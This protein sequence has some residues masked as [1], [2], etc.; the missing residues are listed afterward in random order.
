LSVAL[1]ALAIG[2]GALQ[3]AAKLTITGTVT[4]TCNTHI[5]GQASASITV[6]PVTALSGTSTLA[7]TVPSVPAGL[8]VSPSTSQTLNATTAKT[9]TY[10]V[11]PAAGCSGFTTGTPTLTFFAAGAT[12]AS[13]TVHDTLSSAPALSVS[14]SPATLTCN[15]QSGVA[16]PPTLTVTPAATLGANQTIPVAIPTPP[17]G[18]TIT[19]VSGTTLSSSVTSLSYTVNTASSCAN[20]TNGGT[21]SFNFTANGITDAS[22]TVNEVVTSNT[23]LLLSQYS[24]APTCDTTKGPV[25]QPIVVTPAIP[26]TSGTIAVTFTPPS[27]GLT[28]TAPNVTTLSPTVT[29]LT[30]TVSEAAGCVGV[31]NNG[32]PSVVFNAGGTPDAT[33]TTTTTLANSTSGLAVNNAIIN[34]NCTLVGTTYTPGAAQVVALT[35]TATGGTPFS[36]DIT[37]LTEFF[38]SGG[39]RMRRHPVE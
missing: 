30:Y 35:S 36:M 39:H 12:D 32:T 23:R 25:S 14:P 38:P 15:L 28:V 22:E 8:V 16:S 29:S 9:L 21:G 26:L 27:G 11:S 2:S 33:L 19:P 13:I 24:F 17:S 6:A 31:V 34:L 3:A 18:V 4:L 20:I 7:V 5:A 10:T 37:G 1:A